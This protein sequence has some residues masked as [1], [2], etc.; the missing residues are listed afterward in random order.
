MSPIVNEARKHYRGRIN[1]V[2]ANMDQQSGKE[3]AK[4]YQV[5]GYPTLLLLD[6]KGN[7]VSTL[8]GVMPLA[9]IEKEFENLLAGE[10]K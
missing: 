10:K 1:F 3:L 6:S 5:I 8:R 4:Q 7:K 2:D 9:L